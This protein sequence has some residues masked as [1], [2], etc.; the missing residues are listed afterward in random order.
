MSADYSKFGIIA[1]TK[2][3][4]DALHDS[5]RYIEVSYENFTHSLS[6][7][8]IERGI[9]RWQEIGIL[10]GITNKQIEA[11]KSEA[12][13]N[14]Q[15]RMNDL[16]SYFP[17]MVYQFPFKASTSEEGYEDILRELGRLSRGQ[18][19]PTKISVVTDKAQATT[20][21][22]FYLG[23]TRH[24]FNLKYSA[25]WLEWDFFKH[26][27][28]IVQNSRIRGKFYH[29]LPVDEAGCLIYLYPNQYETLSSEQLLNFDLPN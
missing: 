22:S 23:Q 13:L 15:V 6:R 3:Q 7:K 14:R 5:K 26:V 18:F 9:R 4:E 16:I 29:L 19:L 24:Q 11:G 28:K 12:L 8:Q 27:D 10:H 2:A 21:V 20:H 1:I 25:R 17:T